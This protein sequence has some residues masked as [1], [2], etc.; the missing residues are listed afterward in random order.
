MLSAQER[1]IREQEQRIRDYASAHARLE[2]DFQERTA[3][4]LKLD[5]ENELLHTEMQE[6]QNQF[7]ERTEW[8][9]T[10]DRNGNEWRARIIELEAELREKSRYIEL[11]ERKLRRSFLER[12]L[13]RV[14]RLG[15]AG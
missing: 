6:L 12:A 10:L 3:W 15:H 4:A 14:R 11:L 5:A 8:A 1:R 7:R 9:L 13:N 2:L